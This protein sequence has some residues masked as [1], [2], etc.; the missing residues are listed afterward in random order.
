M[1]RLCPLFSGSGGNSAYISSCGSG[2]LIDAGASC[3]GLLEALERAGGSPEG[4]SAVAITHEHSDHVK[5]LKTLLKRTGLPLIATPDTLAAL[6]KADIIPAGTEIIA[7]GSAPIEIGG[8]IVNAFKTSHDCAGSCGYTVTLADGTRAGVCTDLGFVDDTVRAA[9]SGCSA[10]VIESNHDVEMLRRGPYP[11]Q[12]KLRILS[13]RG[14]LSNNAC[15]AELPRLL[16]SG[17]TRFVLG[18]LSLH[19]NLP[20]LAL[21]AARASLLEAGARENSDYIISAAKP[22][23]NGAVLF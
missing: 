12:L 15:A 2:I 6:N 17:C 18:H 14:H 3:K 4:L 19:N 13:E 9:V 21:S 1:S 22:T 16:E 8:L 11:P 23:D 10:L 7:A 5:G 20:A